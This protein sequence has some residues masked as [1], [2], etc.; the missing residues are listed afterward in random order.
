MEQE[1]VISLTGGETD[2]GGEEN[3]VLTSD[4]AGPSNLTAGPSHATRLGHIAGPSSVV[5]PGPSHLALT[6]HVTEPS[7]VANPSRVIPEPAH[8]AAGAETSLIPGTS[9]GVDPSPMPSTSHV[10]EQSLVAGGSS[11]AFETGEIVEQKQDDSTADVPEETDVETKHETTIA[12]DTQSEHPH[13]E[14]QE[15]PSFETIPERNCIN[16]NEPLEAV[17]EELPTDI[18]DN[19]SENESVIVA[20]QIEE[21]VEVVPSNPS[22]LPTSE[23]NSADLLASAPTLPPT[24][25]DSGGSPPD[26]PEHVKHVPSLLTVPDEEHEPNPATISHIEHKPPATISLV[27][28]KPPS[29]PVHHVDHKPLLAPM[30]PVESRPPPISVLENKYLRGNKDAEA[31]DKRLAEVSDCP[32]LSLVDKVV[33]TD[34][35]TAKG[36]ITVKECTTDEGFFGNNVSAE[37]QALTA[38]D[39]LTST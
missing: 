30:P 19:S 31:V 10:P 9:Y 8:A 26:F 13:L 12:A 14:S 35:T 37:S 3:Q 24:E 27:E 18:F 15:I 28:N 32:N 11:C 34:V 29:V 23:Q 21:R 17:P 6:S 33:I 2:N 22:L 16:L 25:H 39:G 5:A 36:T 1:D 4:V 38:N 7:D 20:P